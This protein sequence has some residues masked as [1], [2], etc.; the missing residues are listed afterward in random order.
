MAE[1]LLNVLA[2]YQS[3][4]TRVAR[5]MKDHPELKT[6]KDVVRKLLDI[7]EAGGF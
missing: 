3:D 6:Q 1:E 2:C 5:I 4:K 7:A